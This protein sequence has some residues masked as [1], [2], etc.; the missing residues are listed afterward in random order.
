MS[1]GLG[2]ALCA[3]CLSCARQ[4]TSVAP[5]IAPAGTS[6]PISAPRS[7]PTP[8]PSAPV[9]SLTAAAGRPLWTRDGQ[10][11]DRA[12]TA[13]DAVVALEAATPPTASLTPAPT[14][15]TGAPVSATPSPTAATTRYRLVVLAAASGAVRATHRL[16]GGDG[17]TPPPGPL[18][19]KAY[20]RAPV[21]A[22]SLPDPSAPS[23]TIEE[24]YGPAG[25]R[26]WRS[27]RDGLR[28]FGDEGEYTTSDGYTKPEI[29][30]PLTPIQQ[31]KTLTG[32]EIATFGPANG[33]QV[34]FVHG[35]AAVV[36]RGRGFRVAT[37]TGNRRTLW[38]SS[39]AA[40][41]GYTSAT[42]VSV[43]GDRLLVQWADTA[44]HHLL[45][46]YDLATG[47]QAW[48]SQTLPGAVTQGGVVEDVDSHIAV[49]G[50]D[51]TGPT[52]GVNART[53]KILWS[54]ASRQNVR[55][56]AG[57]HGRVYGASGDTALAID[58]RTG[59]IT[60]LGTHVEIIGLAGDGVL[61]LRGATSPVAGRI[62]ALRP[63]AE[64]P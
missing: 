10:A 24:A 34:T 47:E 45:A 9:A 20:R 1:L 17:R 27:P 43:L 39:Q 4:P 36:T 28:L 5:P 8:S 19:A 21:A 2:A 30:G 63:S 42:P 55:P 50:S 37:V 48:R 32:A 29:G 62:W 23:A 40:P 58:A 38:S 35:G 22:L 44:A 26:V 54:I 13:G 57:A 7:A 3:L 64:G 6:A 51:G 60:T 49:I 56:V 52:L 59:R 11:S 15:P 46:L 31:L 14:A 12:V 33:E 53:G 61:V 25:R 16:G 18:S 41:H